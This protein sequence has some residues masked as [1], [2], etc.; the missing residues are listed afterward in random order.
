MRTANLTG[1]VLTVAT[2]N[3]AFCQTPGPNGGAMLNGSAKR[4]PLVLTARQLTTE[5][6]RRLM[7]SKKPI[8]D[9]DIP[10]LHR[11][12]DGVAAEIAAIMTTRGPLNRTEQQ[13]VV[14]ILHDAFRHPGS[15]MTRSNQTTPT[16][17]LALLDQLSAGTED[18]NFK[19]VILDTRWFVLEAS[20]WQRSDSATGDGAPK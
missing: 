11:M 4:P 2:L 12:C 20:A 16:A 1:L 13:N 14:E 10:L 19:K 5:R 7:S 3:V 18:S 6:I 15:I 17:T 9:I 8:T